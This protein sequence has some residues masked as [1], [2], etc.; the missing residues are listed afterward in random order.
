MV[1][2]RAGVVLLSISW[3]YGPHKVVPQHGC[4]KVVDTLLGVYVCFWVN[5]ESANLNLKHA[6]AG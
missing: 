3:I 1:H 6:C 2:Y 5:V 4:C